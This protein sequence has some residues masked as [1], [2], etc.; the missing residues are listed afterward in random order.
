M[1]TNLSDLQV[2]ALDCQATGASPEKGHLLE[3]GWVKT[4]AGATFR[5]KALPVKS[6]LAGLP[7]DVDIPPAVQRVT[8][9][10]SEALEKALTP[11]DIWQKVIKTAKEIAAA[12]HMDTCPA[13]IH[14]ARFEEPFLRDLHV[15][16]KRQDG[17]PLQIICT[18]EIAKRL[19][20]GL[21]R[22]GLRAVAGY[23]GH[24]VPPSR[25]SA[26]HAV[27]TAVIWHN[28]ILQLKADHD[29][30]NLNQLTDWL[31][32]PSPQSRTGRV[33]PMKRE[34]RLNLPEKPGIYRMLRSNGDLLYIGKATS[35]KHRVNSYFRQKGS[36]AEHTLEMLSQAAG[37][38]VTL[39]GSAL[40]SAVLESDEIKRHSPP[41]NVALQAGQRKLVFCSR[42]LQK[43]SGKADKIHCIGPLPEGKITAAIPAFSAW[44]PNSHN[45]PPDDFL[46]IGYVILGLPE[47]YA[48]EPDCLTQGLALFRQNHLTRLMQS[49]PLRFLSGLGRKLWHARL[50]ELKKAKSENLQETIAEETADQA[51]EVDE[52]PSW[53]PEAVARAIEKFSMRSALLIRRSRWLCLLSESSLA[54][55]SRNSEGR[56]KIVLLFENGAAGHRQELPI[57]EKTPFSAGYAKRIANRQKI[58]DLATY[59]RLRVVTTELRRLVTEGRKVEIRLRPNAIL[60][61]RQLAKMLPWV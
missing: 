56:S 51:L 37:L 61:N 58:F 12:D 31:S 48:P 8:G 6:C 20:P 33:Y 40:E 38:D 11:D 15:K 60:S 10:Y 16:N 27:A 9:I 49:S 55:E 4:C 57:R 59:E 41:Y 42:D 52:A 45:T 54:W 19:L 28:L 21:P 32:R 3:I 17:F 1:K 46:Q 34:I 43:L 5:P 18:H 30:Q 25:R 50:E 35:L 39:T 14:Y 2:M 24:S 26:D 23:F 53:T 47:A 7:Q 29:I 44:H 22:R 13:I 36:Q